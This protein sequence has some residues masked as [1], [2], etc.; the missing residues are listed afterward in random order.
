M[1]TFLTAAVVVCAATALSFNTATSNAGF[2]DSV[3][4]N[5]VTQDT[6]PGKKDT[7]RSKK[8]TM[9][10]DTTNRMPR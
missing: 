3:I 9:R 6:V 2:S 1:K 5:T 8:D 4:V 10:R 7:M